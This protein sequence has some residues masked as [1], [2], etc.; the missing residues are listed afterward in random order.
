MPIKCQIPQIRLPFSSFPIDNVNLFFFRNLG[1][2]VVSPYIYAT[3]SHRLHTDFNSE[4][5]CTLK[6]APQPDSQYSLLLSDV[7]QRCIASE[8]QGAMLSYNQNLSRLRH[9]SK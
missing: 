6:Q 3:V 9:L 2:T 7:V 4:L 1:F 8:V 5:N